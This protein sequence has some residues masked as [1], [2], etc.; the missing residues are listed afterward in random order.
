MGASEENKEEVAKHT[1]VMWESRMNSKT[2]PNSHHFKSKPPFSPNHQKIFLPPQMLGRVVHRNEWRRKKNIIAR[3][4]SIRC[5]DTLLMLLKNDRRKNCSGKNNFLHLAF[6]APRENYCESAKKV[7]FISKTR[8]PREF[9][10]TTSTPA[11]LS[12]LRRFSRAVVYW[13]VHFSFLLW[14]ILISTIF[15]FT[16]FLFIS[17]RFFF[18]APCDDDVSHTS[19]RL[20]LKTHLAFVF[21]HTFRDCCLC[22]QLRSVRSAADH[23][24]DFCM[25][26]GGSEALLRNKQ[27]S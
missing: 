13:W 26:V 22:N 8:H 4:K 23:W 16:F 27:H 9:Y 24:S 25:Y 15:L 11:R 3:R 19:A 1:W 14:F 20:R 7:L 17:F 6:L 12:P 5:D 18:F 10:E 2:W 21:L